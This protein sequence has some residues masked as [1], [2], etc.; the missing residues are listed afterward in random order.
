M[1]LFGRIKEEK[2]YDGQRK[3]KA[4]ICIAIAVI[5][6]ATLMA[7]I[8]AVSAED[9]TNQYLTLRE[10]A[11]LFLVNPAFVAIELETTNLSM[12]LYMDY[13]TDAVKIGQ[14]LIFSNTDKGDVILI[15]GIADTNTDGEAFSASA[16]VTETVTN[17]NGVA[18]NDKT[19][20]GIYFDTTSMGRTG[21][22]IISCP[23]QGLKQALSVSRPIIPI[24]LKVGPDVVSTIT[25]GT[26]LRLDCSGISDLDPNDCIDLE[27]TN[28]KGHQIKSWTANGVTQY[29]DE[30]NVSTLIEYGS[31][32]ETKQI[33]TTGWLLGPYSFQV[34]TEEENARG[35]DLSSATKTLTM[36]KGEV[37][38][39]IDKTEV[40]EL[41][42]VTVT[43]TGVYGNIIHVEATAGE[44]YVEFEEGLDDCKDTFNRLYTTVCDP[45]T[46]REVIDPMTGMPE[47]HIYGFDLMMEE[48]GQM[49][50]S[51]R[52][53]DTGAYT[54]EVIDYGKDGIPDTADDGDGHTDE[55]AVK[56]LPAISPTTMRL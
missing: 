35:L 51:V 56:I 16:F 52:F 29:Y 38:V 5:I 40:G 25:V 2:M 54:I 18:G 32:D 6:L 27:I 14:E 50:F 49:D 53:H 1:E 19:A 3:G 26:K 33:D 47:R 42:S 30:I 45:M 36:R 7:M 12:Y 24:E 28:P 23:A 10:P 17:V 39:N 8:P 22:Y 46:G 20:S 13:P 43:V 37:D 34:I 44:A 21:T 9:I 4:I 41:E 48:D 11:N 31:S 55:A 15:E